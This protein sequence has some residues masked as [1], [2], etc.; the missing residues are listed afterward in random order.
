M[1]GIY[2]DAQ[3]QPISVA[4]VNE[5]LSKQ[6]AVFCK[7]AEDS[8]G[9]DGVRYIDRTGGGVE[10]TFWNVVKKWKR[11]VIVQKPLSQCEELASLNG[12]SINT[13]RVL[14]LLSLNGSVKIYSYVLR[15]GI[16]GSLMK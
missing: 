14:S 13:I 11:D 10:D 5:I 12:S 4:E 9:G 8:S 2:Y 1:N 6:D 16:G 15:M 7:E 3:M